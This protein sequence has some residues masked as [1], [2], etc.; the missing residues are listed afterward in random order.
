MNQ[1]VEQL[2]AVG[3][4]YGFL[5]SEINAKAYLICKNTDGVNVRW[6]TY[7]KNTDTV[8]LLG[9]TDQCNLWFHETR[10]DL[11]PD[12]LVSFV[13]DLNQ[14]LD[15]KNPFLLKDLI[16]PED[17]QEIAGICDAS[18]DERYIG[19][20]ERC[21]DC[22]KWIYTPAI[23]KRYGEGTGL[24]DGEPKGCDRAACLGFVKRTFVPD[25]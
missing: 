21:G 24:C 9:N 18:Y 16:D 17:W 22:N 19:G 1:T 13:Q 8:T 3:K 2:K 25:I 7:D 10:P 15:I 14:M 5:V 12:R 11:T 23:E 6:I 4:K 20:Q